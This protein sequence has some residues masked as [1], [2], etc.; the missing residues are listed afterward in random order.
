VLVTP[1]G[2]DI[3]ASVWCDDGMDFPA[4]RAISL[5]TAGYGVFAL[6]RPGHLPD[7]L[8]ATGTERG[9]LTS[10][11]RG[12]G[13]RD[14]VVSGAALLGRG[15]LVRAAMVTRA[16]LDVSDCV[17]LLRRTDDRALRAKVAVATLGWATLNTA[18]LVRDE[19]RG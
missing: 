13:V 4:S 17:L 19:R 10:L 9:R 15:R 1:A 7:V 3:V 14:L 8:H 6:A 12:Y 2:G 16:L 5:A 11:A 18:A